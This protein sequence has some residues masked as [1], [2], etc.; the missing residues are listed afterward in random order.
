M[1]LPPSESDPGDEVGGEGIVGPADPE[2]PAGSGSPEG[3][4][5]ASVNPLDEYGAPRAFGGDAGSGSPMPHPSAQVPP[6]EP[7]S[8]AGAPGP[9]AGQPGPYAGQ[10]GAYTGQPASPGP[11]PGQPGPPAGP[12]APSGDVPYTPPPVSQGP[13]IGVGVGVGC[14]GVVL[15]ALLGFVLMTS[16]LSSASGLG[17][18]AL[19]APTVVLALVAIG[20]MFS[21]KLR[22]LGLGI[23]IIVASAFLL[24]IGPCSVMLMGI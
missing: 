13:S 23:L 10:P 1:S 8:G 22:N 16:V 12:Y 17:G 21:P 19:M 18:W 5:T 3:P 14:G 2:G 11:Y 24:V 9:Y 15:A 7:G 4:A 6:P 20:L